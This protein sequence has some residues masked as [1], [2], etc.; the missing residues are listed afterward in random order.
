MRTN[1]IK[2]LAIAI[3]VLST[4]AL[5][6]F[7]SNAFGVRS[8]ADEDVAQ[9]FKTKCAACHTPKAE[10]F[11][12]VTKTDDQSVETIL[13]GKKGDKPP[14]MP[15]F[16]AKGMTA[17]QA[18]AL[19]V[20]MRQLK[21]SGTA[22]TNVNS[23]V[24]AN[25]NTNANANVTANTN[26]NVNVNV[27]VNS[28]VKTNANANTNANVNASVNANTS[29]NANI[30][31]NMNA[32]INAK[33]NVNANTNANVNVDIKANAIENVAS[34]YKTKCA[35][36]HTPKAEKFFDAAKADEQLFTIVLKGKKGDK[37]PFMPAFEE[38][39]MHA[40]EARALVAYM[41]QLKAPKP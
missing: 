35:A 26:T 17:E 24:N 19:A 4:L 13:K 22:N 1:Q 18:R 6:A 29:V 7:N 16:E 36:C 39:G 34:V 14:F 2:L 37:P 40:D 38:K 11:F 10:K 15:G 30:N 33:A 21:M 32:N 25:A 27:D 41:K 28:N 5:M 23:V 12:D 8:N 9:T 31:A 3:M 20:Y